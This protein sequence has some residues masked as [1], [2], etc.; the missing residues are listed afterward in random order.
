MARFCFGALKSF[1]R[2]GWRGGAPLG[3]KNGCEF[4]GNRE[5]LFEVEHTD[6][7]YPVEVCMTC[8]TLLGGSS[9][10][11][12]ISDFIEGP[13]WKVSAKGNRWCNFMGH[14]V[15]LNRIPKYRYKL[16]ID[17]VFGRVEYTSEQAAKTAA[18]HFIL[19]KSP[20]LQQ[21]PHQSR[22]LPLAAERED[23]PSD[24]DLQEGALLSEDA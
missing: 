7:Y 6:W 8:S 15:I 24:H 3:K 1:P 4:C 13:H 21:S 11:P 18:W 16:V 10:I 14:H 5:D 20:E 17:S 23:V 22:C 19:S 12:T 9:K 2:S